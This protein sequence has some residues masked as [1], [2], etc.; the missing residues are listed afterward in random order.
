MIPVTIVRPIMSRKI[1]SL[2]TWCFAM[3]S[4]LVWGMT[5]QVSEDSF[6]SESGKMDKV[7]GRFPTLAVSPGHPAFVRFDAGDFSGIIPAKEV[8]GARLTFY[9]TKRKTSGDV[10]LHRVTSEW[11]ESPSGPR[12]VPSYAGKPLATLRASSL[13]E[14][15]F[16][17]IDVTDLAKRWLA[18]PEEDFGFALVADGKASLL[19]PSKEGPAKGLSATLEIDHQPPIDNSRITAGLDPAKLGAGAVNDAEFGFLN[20]VSSP[21]QSQ[22]DALG[23]EIDHLDAGA[24]DW[25]SIT[26]EL[27]NDL[28][29]L[30]T[31]GG[32]TGLLE[33]FD[34]PSRWAE[35]ATIAHSVSQPKI[36]PDK[37]WIT[38]GGFPAPRV[39][40]GG[41]GAYGNSLWYL[42]STV[43]T[44]DSKMS[45]GFIFSLLK[46]PTATTGYNNAMNISFSNIPMQDP[47]TAD[48]HPEGVIHCNFGLNGV[49]SIEYYRD[50]LRT[51]S[52]NSSTTV[53]VT[54]GTTSGLVAGMYVASPG[55]ATGTTIVSITDATHFV[56]SAAASAT[57]S[58]VEVSI[59]NPGYGPF[60][61]KNATYIG[62][63]YPWNGQPGAI[64]ALNK[65][66]AL[67]VKVDGDDLTF[68]VPGVG[69]LTFYQE[70][71]H[72]KIGSTKTYFWWEDGR[73]DAYKAQGRLH[74]VWGGSNNSLDNDPAYGAFIGGATPSLN[75]AGPHIL[76]GTLGL[77]PSNPSGISGGFVTNDP[78]PNVGYGLLIGATGANA[79]ANA[80]GG[81]AKIEGA[82]VSN[83][84]RTDSPAWAVATMA[85]A[86]GPVTATSTAVTGSAV[87]L[88]P[89]ITRL[90][91]VQPGDR[92]SIEITGDLLAG[93]KTLAVQVYATGET[94]GT[95]GPVSS[96]GSF[97]W[98][99]S[100]KTH[101]GNTDVCRAELYIG[102]TL[103]YVNRI[104][105][106]NPNPYPYQL[107]V[108]Q[109]TANCVIVDDVKNVAEKTKLR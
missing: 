34:D 92:Q 69:S 8:T 47:A 50:T 101:T 54:A 70:N 84:D 108:T 60:I 65:R 98:K 99:I 10:A 6:P 109:D 38:H 71:L 80:L 72:T 48:I 3:V 25:L 66:Y 73:H 39:Q 11:S 26:S 35:N 64:L 21:V 40:G 1:V 79:G 46:N 30:E 100:R 91:N 5:L 22:L 2:L 97:A 56:I 42:G 43:P 102:T 106:N 75:G 83:V 16:V 41:Y 14:G 29:D 27:R 7:S 87:A 103:V 93:T 55:I 33:N 86:N 77:F 19:I 18:S 105:F 4:P 90:R 20:G 49:A 28:E 61:C 85:L 45:L 67:L 51:C 37:W 88:V 9:I 74:R 58:G 95:Y 31:G 32:A 17:I 15:Q 89:G 104:V 82:Y 13:R 81:N 107:N 53:T 63:S 68:T 52:T 62:D 44:S 12:K 76:P 36:G 57:A 94:I 23:R 59:S 24:T 96:T 78:G